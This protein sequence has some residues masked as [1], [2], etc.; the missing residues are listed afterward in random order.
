MNDHA[1]KQE[2]IVGATII[3]IVSWIITGISINEL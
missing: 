2:M 3:S 1:S